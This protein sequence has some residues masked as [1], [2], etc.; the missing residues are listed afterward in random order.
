MRCAPPSRPSRRTPPGSSVTRRCATRCTGCSCSSADG[1]SKASSPAP[2]RRTRRSGCL[3]SCSAA[4]SS[5][6]WAAAA[7]AC[8]SWLPWPRRSRTW[9]RRRLPTASPGCTACW[10]ARSRR[11]STRRRCSR[12]SRCTTPGS[13]TAA[14]SPP[15][16]PR[17]RGASWRASPGATSAGRRPRRGSRTPWRPTL[18][19]VAV[20]PTR[21]TGSSRWRRRSASATTRST[22]WSAAASRSP[23]ASS[24]AA[25]GA[26]GCPHST[27]RASTATG[28]S[29]SAPSTCASLGPST[30]PSRA[31]P[32]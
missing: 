28:S 12:P 17:R 5:A 9:S 25:L 3:R 15:A 7:P 10:T 30:S 22:T 14:T 21:S 1:T 31:R 8:T 32:R 26:C 11:A 24:R 27:G 23:W 4:W 2:T 18:P 16:A 13:S 29:T 20:A 19:R 6:A